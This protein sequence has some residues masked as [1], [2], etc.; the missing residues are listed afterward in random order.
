MIGLGIMDVETAV[1]QAQAPGEFDVLSFI[2]GTAYPTETVKVYTDA[3]SATDLLNANQKR[4]DMDKSDEKSDYTDIDS[5]IE[6]LIQKIESSALTFEL[7]GMPPGVTQEIYNFAEDAE[8][9]VVRTAENKLIAATI[10]SVTNAQGSRDGRIWDGEAVDGLRK[11][12]KEGEFGKLVKGVVN[13]NFNAA[14]F[15]QATDAGFLG[16]SSDVE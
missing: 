8:D 7:R 11:F 16:R 14:V 2:S 10:V 1:T 3:K 6:E 13:V 5:K 4:L 9:N 15:D 12:L